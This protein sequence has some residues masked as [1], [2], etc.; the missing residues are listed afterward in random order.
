MFIGFLDGFSVVLWGVVL[1][2]SRVS[3]FSSVFFIVFVVASCGF[4]VF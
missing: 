4:V 3:S 2:V 1:K